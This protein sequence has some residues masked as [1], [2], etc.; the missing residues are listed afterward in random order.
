[1]QH[2]E[3]GPDGARMGYVEIEGDRPTLVY[4]HGLGAAAA[5][6]FTPT[7]T[8]PGFAGR[9]AVMPDL[10]GFGLSDRPASFGYA[11]ADQADAVA[12]VLDSLGVRGAD[13]VAH[14]LGGGVGVLL[15]D[16]RPD[17]VG[18]LVL[19]EPSL[20]PT[21]RPFVEHC[22]EEEFVA[23]G[24][25]QRLEAA[26]PT[27]AATMRLA[28]PVAQYRS[29]HAL[30]AGMPRLTGT[31][32]GL[33]M[34]RAVVEGELTGWLADDPALRAAGIPVHVVAGADH[35]PMLG[36]PAGFARALAAAF[37]TAA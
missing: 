11:L 30:G 25:A 22:T 32:L 21:P 10:L 34:P 13:V 23:T 18:R 31:L 4:V 35:T 24:F 29:E 6:Y 3:V 1:M 20:E 16:R 37:A 9:H 27:W 36:E 28:D 7:A 12:R 33:P 5:P 8:G 2:V 17:L 26:G 19:V 14:S 15:A